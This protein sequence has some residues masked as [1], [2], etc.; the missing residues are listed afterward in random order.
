MP[1]RARFS[2][3]K[4]LDNLIPQVAVALRAFDQAQL[5]H[6][7]SQIVAVAPER[8]AQVASAEDTMLA[9]LD[10][11][12]LG[13]AVS[14]RQWRDILGILRVQAGKLDDTYL[15]RMARSLDVTDLLRRAQLEAEQGAGP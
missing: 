7:E 13:G 15:Q 8:R 14:E 9:K 5:A 10:W 11:Y 2:V 3:D 4:A 12:R 6:G 1:S